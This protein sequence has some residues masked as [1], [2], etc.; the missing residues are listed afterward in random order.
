MIGHPGS[1]FGFASSFIIL[2]DVDVG[3]YITTT[4]GN[5][6]L[7]ILTAMFIMDV[8]LGE[9][10]WLDLTTACTFPAP[11]VQLHAQHNNNNINT[12]TGPDVTMKPKSTTPNQLQ[13]NIEQY[14]GKFGNF[15]YGNLSLYESEQCMLMLAYGH[16]VWCLEYIGLNTFTGHGVD[17]FWPIA[18]PEVVFKSSVNDKTFDKVMLNFYYGDKPLFVRDLKIDN[19]Y[20]PPDNTDCSG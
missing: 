4:P 3:V 5:D 9:E 18:I 1:Y 2:P 8:M 19:A 7:T 11:W 15:A 20:P 6:F 10:P 13:F 16:V 12:S 14:V 17:T